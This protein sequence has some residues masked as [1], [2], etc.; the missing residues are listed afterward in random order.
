MTTP[1]LVKNYFIINSLK[2]AIFLFLIA[3]LFVITPTSQV[4]F[5]VISLFLFINPFISFIINSKVLKYVDKGI[6]P[7]IWFFIIDGIIFMMSVYAFHINTPGLSEDSGLIAFIVGICLLFIALLSTL[8]IKLP[9]FLYILKKS[10]KI[11]VDCSVSKC[12][13]K[14]ESKLDKNDV[15]T[16]YNGSL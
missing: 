6:G 11:E 14:A 3:S 12:I 15:D 7:S 9:I 2:L 5:I 16:S 10:S 13:P 8:F 4:V 1:I